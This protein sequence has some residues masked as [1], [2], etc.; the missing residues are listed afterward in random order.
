MRAACVLVLLLG[1]TSSGAQAPSPLAPVDP[2]G[3]WRGT[4]SVGGTQLRIALHLGRTSTFDSP[5]QGANGLPAQMNVTDGKVTVVLR[6][7]GQFT[8]TLSADGQ[9][10][11]G[12]YAQGGASFPLRF[13]RGSFKAIARPQ[14]PRPPFPYQSVETRYANP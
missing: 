1:A 5:D 6:G 2:S 14:T 8:G 12:T 10:M 7:A 4:L 9:A 3:D 13:E 11:E